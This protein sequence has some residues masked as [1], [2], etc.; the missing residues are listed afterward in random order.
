MRT[1][2]YQSLI[3]VLLFVAGTYAQEPAKHPLPIA[4]V[5]VLHIYKH[6]KPVV[7]KTE[8]IK[9]TLQELE[10]TVQ[11]RQVE[12][13]TLQ[14]RLLAPPKSGEDR[15]RGQLQLAKLQT[16]LRLFVERERQNI[17]KR[18]IGMQVEVYKQIQVEVQRIA[19]ERGLKLVLVKAQRSLE[20]ENLAEVSQALNQ[21]ILYEEGIDI[22]NE[23]LAA[24]DAKLPSAETK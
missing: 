6:H 16:E 21:V 11:I 7:E 24:L 8:A 13:E 3:A 22:T 10:K 12:I 17:Q 9:G 15:E 19:K 4:T 2:S 14:R 1:G 20:S 23:V 18:E 5:D